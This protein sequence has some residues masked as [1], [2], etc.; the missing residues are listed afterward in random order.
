MR[1]NRG[2]LWPV[3]RALAGARLAWTREPR[4]PRFG[5]TERALT[6]VERLHRH[7]PIA[8]RSL[9]ACNHLSALQ[10][11]PSLGGFCRVRSIDRKSRKHQF[12][13]GKWLE[14]E[15]KG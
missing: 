6:R 10:T 7:R 15:T 9:A 3:R 8:R 2:G 14:K 11:R 5:R 13:A 4:W 1:R 12:R